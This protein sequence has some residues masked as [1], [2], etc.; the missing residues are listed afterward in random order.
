MKILKVEFENI[1]SLAGKWCIDFTDPSYSELDHSLFVI[2]GKTGMGKTSILDAITI[3][4]YGAT[5]RQGVIYNGNDGNAVMT[6]D[7]GTCFAR[8]TYR[9]R[10]GTYVSEWNQRRARDKADGNLQPAHG[11]VWS[12]DSPE[13]PVFDGNTGKNGELGKANAEVIQLDYSQ[14]CRSIMLAQGEFSK[15]LTSDERERADILEKLNGTEKYR[16]IGKKVGDHR[17][18]AKAAK[19]TSQAAFDALNNTM[20]KA[21]DIEKDKALLAEVADKEKALTD[22]KKD[23]E[24]RIAWRNS[25]NESTRSLESAET[26]LAKANKDKSEFAGNEKRLADAEKARECATLHTELQ[27][28]RKH[29]ASDKAKLEN[30]QKQLPQVASDLKTAGD[31]KAIAEKEKTAT[32]QFI[33]ENEA[34]WNEIRKLDQNVKNATSVKAEAENRKA[35]AAQSLSEAEAELKKAQDAIK[36]LEPQVESLAQ[37]QEANAKDA[38]LAGIIPQSETLVASI[39]GFDKKIADEE[40]AKKVAAEDLKKAEEGLNDANALKQELLEQQNELFRNDILALANVIQNHLEEGKACPVCGSTEH[41]ACGHS[42]E[43]EADKSRVRNTAEKIRE[44]NTK[45]LDVDTKLG[46]YENARSRALTAGNATNEN[47]ESLTGQKNEASEKVAELWKPWAEFDLTN[48]DSTLADLKL[49]LQQFTANKTKFDKL[50]ND[51]A[52]A[53]NNV[54]LYGKKVQHEQDHLEKETANLDDVSRKLDE[55]RSSRNEKFGDKDVEAVAKDATASKTAAANKYDAADTAFRNIENR[56]NELNTQ[57][58]ALKGSLE[59]TAGDIKTATEKFVNA[60]AAKGF[61]DEAAFQA[62]LLQEAEFTKLQNEKKRIDAA[63]ATA[64]GKKQAATGTLEKLKAE[65]S[66][67]MP[68]QALTEGKVA[69]EKELGELQGSSGAA[70]ARVKAYTENV[71]QLQILQKDLDAK[72]AELSRWDAMGEWF[73]V[74][75]GSD[76]AT[77]VQGLTFKS[78]LKLANKHLAI[79]KDRFRLVAEGNLGFKVV[80][81]EFDSARRISN[82]SGG[83]KFL[84]SLSLAL[85]IA[86]FA[87][88]NVRVESLFMDEGFGTL[89][90]VTLEDVMSCLRCQQREGKMLGIITHVESVVNSINQKIM[91]ERSTSQKGHSTITGPGVTRVA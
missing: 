57:I 35:T 47:I 41:P 17:R 4:L 62:A 18:E 29:E 13:N 9:C 8:V 30:F 19:D 77:F 65:R 55:L 32:E 53:R 11:K 16:R 27:G 58:L 73:G 70:R 36:S 34:L 23:L 71:A 86:D 79:V 12:I 52:I 80:D 67:E 49:R 31:N 50:S 22:K 59:K 24:A 51:L 75:D 69:V 66:D 45:M 37:T 26:E 39:R 10:K 5:P 68:L 89:D 84:V 83:E 56:H 48:A 76:F 54:E 44:L 40:K 91:L 3:A 42:E 74:M 25:M 46:K 28:L 78:L 2:S 90:D 14:F 82:L 64:T 88:R 20:L 6:S 38:E 63:I 33:A 61:A 60:I 1:N 85:G 7:K 87:S 43:T 21:E 81:S 72:K 15:F